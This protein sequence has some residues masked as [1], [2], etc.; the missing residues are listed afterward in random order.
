M[1]VLLGQLTDTTQGLFEALQ[2]SETWL[3]LSNKHRSIDDYGHCL[4]QLYGAQ[5]LRDIALHQY[6][7]WPSTHLPTAR[8]LP[9]LERDLCLLGIPVKPLSEQPLVTAQSI[10]QLCSSYEGFVAAFYVDEQLRLIHDSVAQGVPQ[11]WPRHYLTGAAMR[12]R[13]PQARDFIAH[14][15]HGG[16]DAIEVS[17][18]AQEHLVRLLET[19]SDYRLHGESAQGKGQLVSH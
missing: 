4:A 11:H 12:Y 19:V 2:H 16:L 10:T 13:W 5:H 9:A 7:N 18:L 17:W 15:I 6:G 3:V 14:K 8:Q 1:S